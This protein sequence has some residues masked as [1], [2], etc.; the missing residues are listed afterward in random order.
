MFKQPEVQTLML[1]AC[2]P[3]Y[4]NQNTS[5]EPA[6]AHNSLYGLPT[7]IVDMNQNTS[8]EPALADYS[9]CGLPYIYRGHFFSKVSLTTL[10]LFKVLYCSI[11]V[12]ILSEAITG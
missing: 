8:T 7:F 1:V 6:L 4:T 10:M 3:L 5:T 11:T 9:L 2:T 12:N